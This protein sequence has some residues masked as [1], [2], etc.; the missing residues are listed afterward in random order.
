[1]KVT[2]L[3]FN[4]PGEGEML[5]KQIDAPD[6]EMPVDAF[7][8]GE[9]SIRAMK[10]FWPD[11]NSTHAWANLPMGRA[12]VAIVDTERIVVKGSHWQVEWSTDDYN[13]KREDFVSRLMQGKASFGEIIARAEE[14]TTSMV[15][16]LTNHQHREGVPA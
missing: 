5:R 10:H 12:L 9:R 6:N 14:G 1:M 16:D 2:A 8:A 15:C 3:L 13:A 11:G 7:S 4:P